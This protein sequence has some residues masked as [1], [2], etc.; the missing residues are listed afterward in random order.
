LLGSLPLAKEEE[1]LALK[2]LKTNRKIK[3]IGREVMTKKQTEKKSEK[4]YIVTF[5]DSTT[6]QSSAAAILDISENSI[7]DGVSLL[8]TDAELKS[9]DILHLGG[10]GISSLTL[11]EADAEKYRGDERILAVEEDIQ[12]FALNDDSEIW[13]ENP[14]NSATQDEL[15]AQYYQQGYQQGIRDLYQK[16]LADAKAL[17]GSVPTPITAAIAAASQPI[18]WNIAMVN[19]PKAWVR[20]FDG[21]GVK[22]AVL[23]TGIAN[24]PDLVISGGVSFVPNVVSFNDDVGHG[25]HCAGIIGARNNGIGVVGVA[26]S[27]S[28][29]AVKVL[30]KVVINGQV[31]GSGST[32]WILTGMDW[33]KQNGMHVVSMS[34]GSESCQSIAYTTTIAQLNAAGVT[35]VCAAGNSGIKAFKCVN[36]PGNSPGAIAVAAVDSSKVRPSFSSF[37]V[38][39]CPS[40]ANP[41]NISA[42]GVSINSTLRTGGYGLMSGTSMACPHVA[43]V[44]ALIKQRFP[45][46]TP[47]QIRSKLLSTAADIGVP[48]N[49]ISYG[50]GLAD[51]DLATRP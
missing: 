2:L 22:V 38:T 26:P 35:V 12:M 33:A 24:H 41:V 21:R 17:H 27:V 47:A 13:Q 43:G 40:G 8:S 45:T 34:L 44:V 10:L 11:S 37:G 46:F 18:P 25:T 28:L 9:S 42:P 15:L 6:D 39:C 4:R 7:Q 30:Q 16:I 23:D 5:A 48:G 29:Y 20:G 19:A 1:N 3:Q 31:S 36:S 32:L 14:F 50:A 49:D 51:C